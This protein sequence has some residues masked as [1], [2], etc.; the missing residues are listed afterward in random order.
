MVTETLG[1]CIFKR[2]DGFL[3]K[4]QNETGRKKMHTSA[5]TGA[6]AW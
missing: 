6:F 5:N 3:K 2:K 4:T 1:V